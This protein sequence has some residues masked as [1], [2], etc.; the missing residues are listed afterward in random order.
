L[1]IGATLD[2]RAVAAASVMRRTH[3]LRHSLENDQILLAK[4]L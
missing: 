2:R 4:S 3:A 1:R